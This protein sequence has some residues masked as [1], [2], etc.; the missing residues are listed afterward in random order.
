MLDTIIS[1]RLN[2]RK[3]CHIKRVFT[4]EECAE[5]LQHGKHYCYNVSW[6]KFTLKHL[7]GRKELKFYS[8]DRLYYLPPDCILRLQD[9]L[10]SCF[11]NI[12]YIRF[13]L[14]WSLSNCNAQPLHADDHEYYDSQDEHGNRDFESAPYSIVIA[15]EPDNNPSRLLLETRDEQITTRKLKQGYG[16]VMRGDQRHAGAAYRKHNFRLFIALG[17]EEYRNKGR[18]TGGIDPR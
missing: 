1:M 14:I 6:I 4:P 18:Y 10:M 15:L 11:P 5:I 3:W 2:R 13:S 16:I 8:N 7:V 9:D 12:R 17:T